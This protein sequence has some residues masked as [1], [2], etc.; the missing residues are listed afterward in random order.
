MQSTLRGRQHIPL[1]PR[2]PSHRRAVGRVSF[3]LRFKGLLALLR[4]RA[5]RVSAVPA[6]E[7]ARAL[8]RV[9]VRGRPRLRARPEAVDWVEAAAI[10]LFAGEWAREPLREP[11]RD[12]VAVVD[13]AVRRTH[14]LPHE[15]VRDGANQVV[16]WRFVLLRW[17][18]GYRLVARPEADE[19]RR[20]FAG[21]VVRHFFFRAA[22]LISAE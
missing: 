3:R 10:Q 13:A 2:S 15:R 21:L 4:V 12:R 6:A 19:R 18:V 16:G 8:P 17:L 11:A 14:R 5:A 20:A 22:V 1:K 7:E 9:S